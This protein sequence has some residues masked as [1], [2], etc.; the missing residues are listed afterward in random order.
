M[1]K[2]IFVFI[3]SF[4]LISLIFSNVAKATTYTVQSGD[5]LWK[6]ASEHD[7]SLERL[8]NKNK[9]MSTVIHP[10]KV[11]TIPDQ[12]VYYVQQGDTLYRISQKFEVSL[13]QLIKSNPQ[14]E[15]PSKIYVGQPINL[16]IDQQP[17]LIYSGDTDEKKVALTF[18]DGPEDLYTPKILEILK[19]KNVKATFFVVGKQ[20]EEFPEMLKKIHN[21]GH[22]IGNHTWGHN[23][24]KQL[25]DDQIIQN[26]QQTTAAIEH[27]IGEETILF[28]P[29]YGAFQ[30][31]QADVLYNQGYT[32][33]MWSVDTNDWSGATANEVLT[34]THQNI[35]PGGIVLQH[36]F[37]VPGRLDGTVKALPK[38][39]DQLREKGYEFVTVDELIKN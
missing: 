33:V 24:I 37:K 32:S 8:I 3:T 2:R 31:Q 10:G 17:K 22:S 15:A 25:T 28:R 34:R 19:D 6:I 35:S 23:N 11:L 5:S 7:V 4:I 1:H 13:S 14:I 9:L 36:N 16:P 21:E 30:D 26:V 18:D 39:I 20:V 12:D 29:P 27:V 38:M